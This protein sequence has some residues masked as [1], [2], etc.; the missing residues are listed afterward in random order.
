MPN[1]KPEEW[2]TT[3][4]MARI[5]GVTKR[6]YTSVVRPV[7]PPECIKSHGKGKETIWHCRGVIDAWVAHKLKQQV[8]P[9]DDDPEMAGES[10]PA[11]ERYRL[12][13][14]EK[15][16]YN[17]QVMRGELIHVN[18]FLDKYG[19]LAAVLRGAQERMKTQWPEAHQLI[20]EALE[21]FEEELGDG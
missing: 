9:E 19:Q 15:E 17:L 5:F 16:E 8:K 13:R 18:E 1:D 14:A 4:E 11:L 2:F 12:A 10:S 7:V 6:G 21:R 3:N 20:D